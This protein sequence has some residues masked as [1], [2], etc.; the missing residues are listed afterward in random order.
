MPAIHGW[1][2]SGNPPRRIDAALAGT[3]RDRISIWAPY[4]PGSGA[5]GVA[6]PARAGASCRG[7]TCSERRLATPA[8]WT[9]PAEASTDRSKQA[10]TVRGAWEQALAAPG[11]SSQAMTRR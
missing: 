5:P 1:P 9:V 3:S 4:D 10:T 7:T 11:Q 6:G 8:G 2:R